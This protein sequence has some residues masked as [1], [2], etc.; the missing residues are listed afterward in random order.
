MPKSHAHHMIRLELKQTPQELRKLSRGRRPGRFNV[1]LAY[2]GI[3]AARSVTG[4]AASDLFTAN[5]HGF[6]VG[7]Q[8]RFDNVTGGAGITGGQTYHVIASGLTAN[9]F[10]VSAT[11]GGATINFTTDVAAGTV[12]RL[13]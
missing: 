1:L 7:T 8:V 11:P 9:D 12:T 3:G 10:R 6:V 4:I 13:T 5:S 2:L